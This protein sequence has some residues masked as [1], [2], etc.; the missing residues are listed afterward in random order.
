MQG[1]DFDDNFNVLFAGHIH[2]KRRRGETAP[3]QNGA[4]VLDSWHS[5][6]Q[7][8]T[9][10]I[11]MPAKG[12]EDFEARHQPQEPQTGNGVWSSWQLAAQRYTTRMGNPAK[13]PGEFEFPNCDLN[14]D[15]HSMGPIGNANFT[16]ST[17][18]HRHQEEGRVGESSKNSLA[19]SDSTLAP[20]FTSQLLVAR[21]TPSGGGH[22]GHM[23]Q[24][25]SESELQRQSQPMDS[26]CS[27]AQGR[28]NIENEVMRVFG[29]AG[30]GCACSHFGGK[31]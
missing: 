10:R 20:G 18:G 28:A 17:S 19:T 29:G 16:N 24:A 15:Q 8:Y 23:Q 27:R 12:P 13:G 25:A 2:G 21:P 26:S 1:G 7:R 3:S 31:I 6:A 5:A 9:A 14:L 11:N 22:A 4:S 30:V